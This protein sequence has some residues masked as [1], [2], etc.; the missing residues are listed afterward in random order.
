MMNTK[1]ITRCALVM[2]CAA[3]LP[4][5]GFDSDS[6][7]GKKAEQAQKSID[8]KTE[9]KNG[10]DLIAWIKVRNNQTEMQKDAAYSNLKG[11]YIV[12]KGEV[13]EIGETMFGG[14]PYVSLCVGKL[15]L[16][17]NINIQ[18]N[19][20][21]T[22]KAT[23]GEWGKGETRILRGKITGRGDLEDDA[24]C[25]DCSIVTEELY[26]GAGGSVSSKATDIKAEVGKKIMNSVL[27]DKDVEELKSAVNDLKD[28]A[29]ELDELSN[30]LK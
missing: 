27:K 21:K 8:F 2:L 1:L 22:L 7:R 17:E 16:F 20:P 18:F 15:D 4:G 19:V 29:A 25:S 23:V 11:K 12:L 24:S 14:K 3:L 10:E 6:E 26:A 9:I 30:L 28:A 5:C 13:R